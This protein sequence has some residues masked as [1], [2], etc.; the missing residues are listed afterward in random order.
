MSVDFSSI[1]GIPAPAALPPAQPVADQRQALASALP[2]RSDTQSVN[3]GASRAPGFPAS[4]ANV[5]TTGVKASATP[6]PAI[7]PQ[8][9]PAAQKANEAAAR[10]TA[11]EQRARLQ[12]AIARLND[13]VRRNARDLEFSID[14]TLDRPVI[15]VLSRESGE[16]IRQIPT[17][18]VLRIA[19]NIEDLKGLMLNEK[20]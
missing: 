9:D 20:I 5:G 12:E 19:Y 16:I 6:I 15:T 7:A 4:G 8:P 13:Q 2:Q 18:A 14:Q 3:Q 10:A 1:R 17:E 11:Q